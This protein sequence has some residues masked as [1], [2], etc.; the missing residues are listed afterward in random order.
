MTLCDVRSDPGHCVRCPDCTG[1]ARSLVHQAVTAAHG[2]G[3]AVELQETGMSPSYLKSLPGSGE[4][5]DS[6]AAG[7]LSAAATQRPRRSGTIVLG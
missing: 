1:Q 2:H 7:S 6:S 4:G 3:V 5:Q